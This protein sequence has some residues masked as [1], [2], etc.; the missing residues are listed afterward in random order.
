MDRLLTLGE[1]S[2]RLGTPVHR[3]RY[4]LDARGLKPKAKAGNAWVY[5]EQVY[6]RLRVELIPWDGTSP[7]ANPTDQIDRP[8]DGP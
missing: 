8:E 2:R 5:D 1:L 7:A 3:V 6:E 4:L